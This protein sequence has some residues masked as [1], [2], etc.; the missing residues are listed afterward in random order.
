MEDHSSN[1]HLK[2][3]SASQSM[4]WQR[5]HDGCK[6][7]ADTPAHLNCLKFFIF[8]QPPRSAADTFARERERPAGLF[9]P[10]HIESINK[11]SE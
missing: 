11:E 2:Q 3:L 4:T 7:T 5:R 8:P 1:N 10:V 6:L 9:R